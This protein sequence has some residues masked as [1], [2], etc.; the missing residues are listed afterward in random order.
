LSFFAFAATRRGAASVILVFPEYRC[1]GAAPKGSCQSR[2]QS[3]KEPRIAKAPK[4]KRCD[5]KSDDDERGA[6]AVT[7]IVGHGIASL[8]FMSG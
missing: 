4:G 6:L 8:G 7:K 3:Q 2:Q 5:E 1:Q